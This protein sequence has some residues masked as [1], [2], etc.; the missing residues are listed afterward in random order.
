[1]ENFLYIE[2][3]IFKSQLSKKSFTRCF[4]YFQ[5]ILSDFSLKIY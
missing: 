1:M 2:F 4:E 5:L 3:T